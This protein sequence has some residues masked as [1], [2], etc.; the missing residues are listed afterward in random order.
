LEEKED[1]G[2]INEI[3]LELAPVSQ[4]LRGNRPCYR[5]REKR[6][7]I[8]ALGSKTRESAAVHQSG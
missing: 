3:R 8:K 4:K 2:K 1:G 7:I 5:D 6:D